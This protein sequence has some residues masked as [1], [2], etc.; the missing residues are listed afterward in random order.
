VVRNCGNQFFYRNRGAEHEKN[1]SRYSLQ[2][3]N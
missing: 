3:Q 1:I 2:G